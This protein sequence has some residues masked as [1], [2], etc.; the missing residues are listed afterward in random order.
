MILHYHYFK[1]ET[2]YLAIMKQTSNFFLKN[3]VSNLSQYSVSVLKLKLSR[4]LCHQRQWN[5]VIGTIALFTSLQHVKCKIWLTILSR[6]QTMN[7]YKCKE[8][9]CGTLLI[10]GMIWERCIRQNSSKCSWEFND[11]GRFFLRWSDRVRCA[12]M[13]TLRDTY[14]ESDWM[15]VNLWWNF[16]T[17]PSKSNLMQMSDP[18]LNASHTYTGSFNSSRSIINAEVF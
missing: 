3:L 10:K 6:M 13:Y 9:L 12:M 16:M 5:E 15:R 4:D 8:F 18:R 11:D 14:D 7:T 17:I 1:H 2:F